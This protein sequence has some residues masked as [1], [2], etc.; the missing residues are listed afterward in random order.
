MQPYQRAVIQIV[1]AANMRFV[2]VCYEKDGIFLPF[3]RSKN[4]IHPGMEKVRR[5]KVQY[6]RT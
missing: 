2:E 5:R 1:S 6:F 4:L 3:P